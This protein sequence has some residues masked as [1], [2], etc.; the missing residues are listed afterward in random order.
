MLKATTLAVAVFA[1]S[2]SAAGFAA[3]PEEKADKDQYKAE[4][5]KV[6]ADY[7]AAAKACDAMEGA[8]EKAC[9]KQAKADRAKAEA[10]LKAKKPS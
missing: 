6:K 2:L 4:M 9:E 7:K 1:A 3:T 10:D 8:E 5:A